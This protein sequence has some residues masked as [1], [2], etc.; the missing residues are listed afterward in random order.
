VPDLKPWN[1]EKS[2]EIQ[3]TWTRYLRC[4]RWCKK[5]VKMMTQRTCDSPQP[6]HGALCCASNVSGLSDYLRQ[7]I[8]SSHSTALAW[9]YFRQQVLATSSIHSP[10]PKWISQ[11]EKVAH[12][13][14]RRGLMGGT[15]LPQTPEICFRKSLI[16]PTFST[17]HIGL[18]AIRTRRLLPIR[19]AF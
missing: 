5:G 14:I 15:T 11:A 3:A 16:A 1:N 6:R 8:Q 7:Q 18:G 9:A 13:W 2:G 19:L 10:G 12:L 4:N 17:L